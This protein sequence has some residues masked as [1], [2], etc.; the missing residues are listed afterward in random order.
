MSNRFLII[1]GVLVL[2]FFGFLIYQKND[3]SSQTSETTQTSQHTIGEGTK[4]VTLV[5][6]GDFACSACET[7]FPILQQV[8]E[9]YGDEITFQFLS[10]PLVQI[11]G[12][13]NA[14]SAHRAAEAAS[15]Q[16]KFWEM[17]DLLF[18]RQNLW[19]QSSNAAGIMEDYATELS[20]NVE[21]FKTDYASSEVNGT[22]NADIATGNDF[23]VSGTPTFVLNGEKIESPE[24]S[25]EAFS[26]VIDS[27]IQEN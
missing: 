14:M 1:L 16:G 15:N 20:L 21:Q 22:I 18:E 17:H 19:A 8:K 3:D 5:E 9:K 7:Y 2:G 10:F 25:V 11:Q 6:Y 26:E 13:E 4:N 12:H 23:N 24:P 27:A